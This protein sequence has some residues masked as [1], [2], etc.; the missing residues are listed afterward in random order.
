[1]LSTSAMSFQQSTQKMERFIP[2]ITG[3]W[4]LCIIYALMY[5]QITWIPEI[6]HATPHYVCVDVSLDCSFE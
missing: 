1:M 6:T 3:M 2:H 4:E 5:L